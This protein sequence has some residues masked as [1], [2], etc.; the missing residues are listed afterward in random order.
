MIFDD[1]DML[2]ESSDY[3]PPNEKDML[4]SDFRQATQAWEQILFASG[5]LQVLTLH[6]C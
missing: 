4:M 3:R 6:K 1:K 2:T 5:G